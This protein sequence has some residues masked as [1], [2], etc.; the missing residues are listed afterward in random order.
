MSSGVILLN[1]PTNAA[2]TVFKGR[3]IGANDMLN[4]LMSMFRKVERKGAPVVAPVVFTQPQRP[5]RRLRLE[6]A[7]L[8]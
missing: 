3:T 8:A 5:V 1:V 2:A 6:D 7:R 4:W